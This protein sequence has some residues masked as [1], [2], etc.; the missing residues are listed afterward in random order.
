M[1][2]RKD[3]RGLFTITIDGEYSK[4]F[5][6]AIS[7]DVLP[8]SYRLY[9]HIADVSAYVK[10]GGELDIEAGKRGTS[11]YLGNQV[12][13]MLPEILSNNLCSLRQGEDKLTLSAEIV[14]DKNG[15]EINRGFHR[16]IINVNKRLTYKS[17]EDIINKDDNDLHPLL[18]QMYELA[19]ILKK[20]RL[21]KGRIDLN[22]Q[23]YELVFDGQKIKDIIFAKRLK[24]QM[25]IEEFM[26]SANE[27]VSR[28]LTENDMPALYRIHENIS[29]EKLLSLKNFLKTIGF[30]LAVK[31][32]L[33]L[34][35]QKIIDSV[36][37]KKFEQVVNFI[38]LKSFMQAYYGPEPL[39]HFGLGFADYTHF[40]SPI[41][42]YPDLIVH[43]CLK[44]LI[45]KTPPIYDF[46]SLE[47]IG[48]KSS[49]MER[50][51]QNAERDLFKLISCRFME[52][53]IGEVFDAIISGISKGGF[54]VTLIDMPIEG[55]VPLRLLTDDYY[56]VNEDDFTVIGK[57]LGRR[58]RLGDTLKVMLKEVSVELI[59]IDFDVA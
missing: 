20:S 6:D 37:G 3:Y 18:N 28:T 15:K 39:G 49:E 2:G 42:R 54:F 27:V 43:R 29:E 12:I 47:I 56:L 40:T 14:F 8:D 7:L 33:G 25:V 19:L 9:V 32:N 11:F 34:A 59:R 23:D 16:G 21:K 38:M 5:D 24:S 48:D 51:G 46:A 35:L 53:K 26:L 1:S 30:N 55:M 36:I 50:V 41:R 58:F 22:L 52:N 44:S 17:T 4:D 13:P 10:K 31:N 57:R 45:D